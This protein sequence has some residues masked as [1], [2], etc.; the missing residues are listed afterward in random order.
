MRISDWS[1][2]VC[3]SDLFKRVAAGRERLDFQ[4]RM[5][6]YSASDQRWDGQPK[7]E[8]G[9][10]LDGPLLEVL[11]NWLIEGGDT[12]YRVLHTRVALRIGAYAPTPT[13]AP[14]KTHGEYWL[15]S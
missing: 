7:R 6:L 12:G 5:R 15:P 8:R 9:G 13:K 4:R 10:S 1:S 3:S 2:D 14:A 11:F